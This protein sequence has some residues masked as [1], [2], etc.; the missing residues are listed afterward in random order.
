MRASSAS[1]RSSASRGS[2][3]HG[4]KANRRSAR[5]ERASAGSPVEESRLVQRPELEDDLADDV[6]L[7]YRTPLPRVTRHRSVITE[8]E[9]VPGGNLDRE[10]HL[11]APG[12]C[13][14]DG[15]RLVQLLAL[16][17]HLTVPKIGH[18]ALASGHALDVRDVR[19]DP[20]LYYEDASGSRG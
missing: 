16:D 9:Q 4:R 17:H 14:T 8:D 10:A 6:L 13:E 12:R 19:C 7:G 5:A 18:V 3:E 2:F 1:T 15:V 20:R 11:A